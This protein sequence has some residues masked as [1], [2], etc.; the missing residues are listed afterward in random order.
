M[1][2]FLGGRGS[3]SAWGSPLP[4]FKISESA[5]DYIGH[6]GFMFM[7]STYH[8]CEG[9]N[10]YYNTATVAWDLSISDLIQRT[11]GPHLILSYDKYIHTK[12]IFNRIP[13]VLYEIYNFENCS[14][15]TIVL[16]G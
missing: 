6:F 12:D 13:T 5:T 11:A 8:L 9:R 7:L 3:F 16:S 14:L 4:F 2:D 15:S 10:L 1:A